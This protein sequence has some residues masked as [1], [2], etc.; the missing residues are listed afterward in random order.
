MNKNLKVTE[1][2]YFSLLH[3]SVLY[4]CLTFKQEE[5]DVHIKEVNLTLKPVHKTT[6]MDLN[7]E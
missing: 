4:V 2:K 7:Q 3:V 6:K 5:L 1:K